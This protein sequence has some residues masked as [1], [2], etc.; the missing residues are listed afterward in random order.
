ML[1]DIE[2]EPLMIILM[3]KVKAQPLITMLHTLKALELMQE[4]MRLTLKAEDLRRVTQNR[5]TAKFI[6]MAQPE[7]ILIQ[8]APT[9]FHMA[10]IHTQ[11]DPER[12]LLAKQA[13]Q[14]GSE[15][16]QH[17]QMPMR[18]A[19]LRQRAEHRLMQKAV[20][21]ELQTQAHIPK[22]PGQKPPDHTPMPKAAEHTQLGLAPI[23]R[24][25]APTRMEIC[26]TRRVIQ[27]M[28]TVPHHMQKVI[29]Q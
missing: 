5:L 11:K 7:G 6:A 24:G 28:Q 22:D 1:K 19:L 17:R 18:K 29:I 3:Q 27:H 21:H 15:R 10:R 9:L 12:A 2:R 20:E 23:R 14:K 16:R 13:T 26:H 4:V 8:R 25:Q